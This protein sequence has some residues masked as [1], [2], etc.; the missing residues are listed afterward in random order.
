MADS[1]A[2]PALRGE[3]TPT[4]LKLPD[5]MTFEEWKHQLQVVWWMYEWSPWALGDMLRFGADKWP[6][7]YHQAVPISGR[8]LKT[9]RNRA[10]L[11]RQFTPE[12]GTR[13]EI[14]T[15]G[16]H[17]VLSGMSDEEKRKWIRRGE[18]LEKE[19]GGHLT[20]QAWREYVRENRRNPSGA[21][22]E[23]LPSPQKC[24]DCFGS[25]KCPKCHGSGEEHV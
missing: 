24:S 4:G 18:E 25:G 16:H 9:L 22:T 2:L 1:E 11:A 8:A 19:S 12:N 3:I 21:A 6:E 15:P 20:V 17:D 14:L 5:D 7:I 13:S 23:A 10:S